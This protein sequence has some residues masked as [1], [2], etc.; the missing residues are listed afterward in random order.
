MTAK[1]VDDKTEGRVFR[2]TALGDLYNKHR[3][4]PRVQTTYLDFVFFQKV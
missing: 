4:P 3:D 1:N 2:A